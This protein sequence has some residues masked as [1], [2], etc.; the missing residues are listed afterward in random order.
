LLSETSFYNLIRPQ[1]DFEAPEALLAVY[2]PESFASIVMLKD[3]GDRVTFCDH[4]TQMTRER[5]EDQMDTL[6]KLHGRF[7][8]SPQLGAGLAHLF[9]YDNRFEALDRDHDFKGM[10]EA[11]FREAGSS[12]PP[13]LMAREADVWSKT[14]R[15]AQRHG[16]L[17]LT[18][19]HG[20]VHLKNWY[21]TQGGRMGLSDWQVTSKGHWSRDFAYT[22]STALTVEQRRDWE[23]DLLRYYLDRLEA[24]GGDAVSFDEAWLNY[25]QQLLTTL[26]WWTMTLRPGQDVPDMQPRDITLEFI[27]RIAAAIDDL[28]AMDTL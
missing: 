16:E 20:D 14:V 17:P 11:G 3:I 10:C 21:I 6:A 4:R 26:A 27:G 15:A 1:L 2:D 19:T 24:E 18:I 28:D 9:R 23:K 22:I 5:V 8:Q 12:I 25:R 7:Y 13:R